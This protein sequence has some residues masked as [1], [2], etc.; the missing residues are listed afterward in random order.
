M[1]FPLDFLL[2]RKKRVSPKKRDFRRSP[3]KLHIRCENGA[4]W[5][6]IVRIEP[7]FLATSQNQKFA[8]SNAHFFFSE[9]RIKFLEPNLSVSRGAR[10]S[11][12]A[13]KGGRGG[14]C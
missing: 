1:H 7:N 4:L 2:F 5:A 3:A 14:R 12:L 11:G 10:I 8:F 13:N 9:L 6:S